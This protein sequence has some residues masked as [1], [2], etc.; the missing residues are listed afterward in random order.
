MSNW[1]SRYVIVAATGLLAA[2]AAEKSVNAPDRARQQTS[3]SPSRDS[4]RN[5]NSSSAT[6]SFV[7]HNTASVDLV[8]VGE[9]R[10]GVPLQL[11]TSVVGN[12][13]VVSSHGR[14]IAEGGFVD[15]NRN[16]HVVELV[17]PIS[18][19]EHRIS[20]E[21]VFN[22]PGYYQITVSFSMQPAPELTSGIWLQSAS[23]TIWVLIDSVGGRI[24]QS[25]DLEVA[26]AASGLFG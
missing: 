7:T 8:V 13:P 16:S 14:L 3:V 22:N 20:N 2:C 18:V 25:Y 1:N 17:S 24:D 6:A 9:L 15:G 4:V 19:G 5:H 21:I 26:D 12:A 23:K 11:T 10:P